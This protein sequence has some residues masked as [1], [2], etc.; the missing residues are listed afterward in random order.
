VRRHRQLVDGRCGRRGGGAER[1]ERRFHHQPRALT[2]RPAPPTV[3]PAPPTPQRLPPCILL[4]AERALWARQQRAQEAI[5]RALFHLT[6]QR[7]RRRRSVWASDVRQPAC[8]LTVRSGGGDGRR[9]WQEEDRRDALWGAAQA[10]AR[11]LR[12]RFSECRRFR[13]QSLPLHRRRF[14]EC[15]RFRH[16]RHAGASPHTLM[17]L[18]AIQTIRVPFERAPTGR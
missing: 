9:W 12:R 1:R 7:R 3:R 14:S 15:R 6:Q 5:A 16:G 2:C 8:S 17:N 11:R 10:V 13:H 4:G 18:F